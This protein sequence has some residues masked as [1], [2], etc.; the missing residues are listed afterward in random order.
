[1]KF[2]PRFLFL[3][4]VC[5]IAAGGAAQPKSNKVKWSARVQPADV[6]AG[7]SAQVLLTAEIEKGWHI[8]ALNQ[9]EGP[10]S[11]SFELVPNPN[12]SPNGEAIEPKPVVKFDRGFQKDI[13]THAG[14]VT[15][16]LPVFVAKGASG[17]LKAVVKATSQACDE[18][19]CDIPTTVEVPVEITVQPGGPRPDRV[20]PMTAQPRQPEGRPSPTD[21]AQAPV[22]G[23]ASK[24]AVADEIALARRAGLLPYFWL[25]F[26]FGLLALLTPCVWP[27]VPITVSFFSKRT[28]DEQRKNL[29][30]ALA[31]C[32]GI[33]GTFTLLGLVVTL[34]F[35]ASGVQQLAANR[36]VN[37]GLAALFVVLA[38]SLFGFFEFALPASWTSKLQKGSTK[39][40]WIGPV[41]MGLTFSL[42][43]FTCTVPFVGT[44]LVSATK[45]DLFYPIVGMIGFSLAFAIP[46]FFMALF[47]QFLAKMPRSGSWLS[48][49]KAYM[50]FLEIA[51]ALKFLSNAE[52][53]WGLGILTRSVFL[54]CWFIVFSAA[55]LY[56][57]GVF[58]FR[59]DPPD[60][61]IG[62]ARNTVGYVT[63]VA[64]GYCLA[65]A[66][67]ASMGQATGFLPPDPYPGKAGT[68]VAG[69]IEKILWQNN[70]DR[71]VAQ[72]AA[73]RKLVFI[74]FTGYTCTN[75]RVMEG[76]FFP[77]PEIKSRLARMVPVELYTDN[78][79]P[80]NN[81]NAALREKL[82]G[83][84]TNPTY[85]VM[86]PDR[87]V[88]K[89]FQ[90][91]A[92]TQDEF[93]AF[94]DEALSVSP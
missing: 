70:L 44:L 5:L 10:V 84:S 76:E 75:C 49:V 12:V 39:G 37:L 15:F 47:P 54:V 55:A 41:L 77:R 21:A 91:L 78:G 86:K 59:H 65:A 16:A 46:F 30:G 22:Q 34:I 25:S 88:V 33:I 63:A 80:E 74:N 17:N 24:D 57:F 6:R 29:G 8:Y 26:V 66:F 85:V 83:V 79:T 13:G 31:Y 81:A 14:P 18:S 23:G 7:E 61:R 50:G 11:T 92:R 62:P 1:M 64:A 73:E 87:T 28:G 67:G 52:L 90:G 43:T 71:A 35:G 82:T 3:L 38:L 53:V 32:L 93:V 72:A 40:G 94:L 45:G 4:A 60:R 48:A 89:V 9:P 2:I 36:W 20:A 56:L 68:A 58:R 19:S 69:G 51:A 27:M 42:T